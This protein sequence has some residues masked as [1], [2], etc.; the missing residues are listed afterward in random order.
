MNGTATTA[1]HVFGRG[2]ST[3]V[4]PAAGESSP[5][6]SSFGPPPPGWPSRP[7]AAFY[8]PAGR[9]AE[10][11]GPFTEADPV[12]VLVSLLVS[13][14][15]A[16]GSSPHAVA[17]AAHHPAR[18]NAL[19]VGDTSRSRKGSA[20]AHSAKIMGVADCTWSEQCVV[21]G[22][23]SGEGLIER[24]SARGDER[25]LV[26]EPEFARVLIAASRRDSTLS[27]IMR[28]AWDSGRLSVLTRS[29]PLTVAGAHVSVSG[30]IT[31][32]E[33]RSRLIQT[34]IAN[35]FAN[36][37][38]MIL[39]RRWQLRPDGDAAPDSL[40]ERVGTELREALTAFRRLQ[41]FR[42]TPEAAGYW[43][44]LYRRI[45]DD[46]PSGLVGALTARAEA[47]VLR[48]SVAYAG[49]DGTSEI[50]VVHLHAAWTLWNYSAESATYVFG[51]RSRDAYAHRLLHA[52]VS[53]H[54]EGLDGTQ[55]R[56]L[57][58]R[59]AEKGRL[60]AAREALE[61]D[62]LATTRKQGGTGGRARMVTY[63]ILPDP[64]TEAT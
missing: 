48:L 49:L 18:L 16:A 52:L 51:N 57:F 54:P 9:A 22:L 35:G 42:R 4:E 15:N 38:L 45:A 28:Q 47:H 19:T 17:L 41:R 23:A 64:A 25:L 53:V 5:R 12:A 50:D 58:D 8:G 2:E 24:L 56:D 10:A 32:E 30:Q 43:A 34:E 14:G 11:L 61:A 1:V 39:A 6:V 20:H 7:D 21:S 46:T 29:N 36:R 55:Q 33:L 44:D 3:R 31:I 13:L 26:D 27:T 62:G 59:H 63:A 37:F 40:Y 60:D